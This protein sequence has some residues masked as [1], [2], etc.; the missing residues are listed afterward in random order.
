M[1]LIDI[2]GHSIQ[3]HNNKPSSQMHMEHSPGKT[4]SW[5]TNQTSMNLRK[6]K[7]ISSIFSDHSAMRLDVNY[8]KKKKNCKKHKHMEKKQRVSK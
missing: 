1:E 7:F 2:F 6:L 5:I 3:M 4:T 8:K